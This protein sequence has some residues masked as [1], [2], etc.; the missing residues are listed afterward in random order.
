VQW[1]C[2]YFWRQPL[3]SEFGT[4]ETV[5]AKFWPWL[6]PSLAKIV[7]HQVVDFALGSGSGE[8]QRLERRHQKTMGVGVWIKGAGYMVWGLGDGVER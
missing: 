1:W 2:S 7:K 5:K 4:V 8:L 6:E 3:S